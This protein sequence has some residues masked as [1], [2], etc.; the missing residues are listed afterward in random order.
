MAEH[1][2][3]HDLDGVWQALLA[4]GDEDN[5]VAAVLRS[6]GIKGRQKE[7]CACPVANYLAGIFG[8]KSTPEVDGA[9]VKLLGW[10]HRQHMDL[11]DAVTDF[12]LSFDGDVYPD[13]IEEQANA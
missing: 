1:T 4:L 5:K 10:D 11:P 9:T 2:Y 3:S 7:A 8:D 12:V 6:K 13:L